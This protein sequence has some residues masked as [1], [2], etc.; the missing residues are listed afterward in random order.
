MPRNF[1]RMVAF[2]RVLNL[3]L[4]SGVAGECALGSIFGRDV[5][6]FW[7]LVFVTAVPL[8]LLLLLNLWKQCYKDPKTRQSFDYASLVVTFIVLPSA[9]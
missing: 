4:F 6:F 2:L 8:L 5:N 3:E 1:S 7:E 9:T